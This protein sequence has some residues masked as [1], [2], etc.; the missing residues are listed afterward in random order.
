M[1]RAIY[2]S[3]KKYSLPMRKE[4]V[5]VRID[6]APDGTPQVLVSLSDPKDVRDRGQ[7][8]FGGPQMM[9]AFGSMDDLMKNINKIFTSQVMGGFTTNLKLTI[10][11]Y[12]D[13]GI[14]VGDKIYLDI[15]KPDAYAAPSEVVLGPD[16]M[17]KYE[18]VVSMLGD[19]G[20]G[21]SEWSAKRNEILAMIN[22]GVP[23]KEIADTVIRN[24]KGK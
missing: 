23:P 9:G 4:Y 2:I 21:P 17:Q 12:E 24:V 11:E 5:V 6:A 15:I 7:G 8:Q 13:S 14:K 10:K 16:Q 20:I 19:A 3:E 22:K 1:A 18:T